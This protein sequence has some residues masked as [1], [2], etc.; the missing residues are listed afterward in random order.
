MVV[1]G[2]LGDDSDESAALVSA[3]R[4][5][6]TY[7][8]E[9]R[10][11]GEEAPPVTAA[12]PSSSDPLEYAAV[13]GAEDGSLLSQFHED[14]IKQVRSKQQVDNSLLKYPSRSCKNL[15]I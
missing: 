14:A 15:N 10:E 6:S 2:G 1:A 7:T 3:R 4:T 13:G 12:R 5:N 11:E 9:G 8:M